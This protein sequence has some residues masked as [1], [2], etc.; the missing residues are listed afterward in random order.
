MNFAW[1]FALVSFIS[2]GAGAYL[3]GYLRKKGENLATHEDID[4]LVDQVAAVT[5][6]TKTIEATISNEVWDRQRRWE[7]KKE[8][9]FAVAKS[10][11][12]IDDALVGLYSVKQLAQNKGGDPTWN[13]TVV[14]AH[15]RFSTALTKF[16]EAKLLVGITCRKESDEAIRDFGL[17][18]GQIGVCLTRKDLE[19]YTTSQDELSRKLF[20]A[21]AAVRRELGI[22][23]A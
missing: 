10:L 9:L 22:D 18:A 14:Q 4:K 1:T 8:V 17:F 5:Q 23:G 20:K 12:E 15:K 3:G 11:A 2:A 6:T 21:M 13:E 19:T 16:E 7:L